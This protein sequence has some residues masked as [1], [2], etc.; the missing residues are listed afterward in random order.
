MDLDNVFAIYGDANVMQYIRAPMS[1]LAAKELL[2]SQIGGY[3]ATHPLGRFAVVE[4]QTERY[5]GNFVLKASDAVE[6]IEIGYAFLQNDWG[7][8]YAT[9][10]TKAGLEYAFETAGLQHLFAIT[11]VGNI[12]SQRVL[13]KCGFT[14]LPDMVHEDNEVCLFEIVRRETSGIARLTNTHA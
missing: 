14:Q 9:E 8:G 12:A 6:G 7:K 11:S 5:T 3:D 10:L 13:L 4:Q 1:K 2:D